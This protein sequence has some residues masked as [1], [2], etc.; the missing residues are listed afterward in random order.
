M[1]LG[2]DWGRGRGQEAGTGGRG[3][4]RRLRQGPGQGQ[5]RF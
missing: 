4:D 3:W 2:L 1:E 5:I